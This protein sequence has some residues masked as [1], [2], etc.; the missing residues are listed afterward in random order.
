ME[1][2]TMHP[3][4]KMIYERKF[5]RKIGIPSYCSSNELVIEVALERAKKTDKPVLIEATANQVNQNGGYTGMYPKDFVD[6]VM[7]IADRVGTKKDLIILG[8]DHLGPLTWKNELEDI[9]ME[10]AK[11][12]VHQYIS[13]GFTKIHLDTSMKLADDA[14]DIVLSTETIARRGVQLYIT[15]M[16]AF[17]E[18]Q[19]R[20]SASVRPVFIIGSEVPIPG[21][22]L[23]LEESVCITSPVDFEDTVDTYKRVFNEFGFADAWTDVIAVVVQPGV[24]FGDEQVFMY[25]REAAK[26]LCDQ[27]KNYPNIVFEGHSTDYQSPACLGEMVEDGIA[28]LKVGPAL[29]FA[30]REALFALDIIEKELIPIYKQAKFS[31]TLEEVMLE[32]PKNWTNHL[33][34]ETKKLSFARKYSFSDRC[35]YYLGEK[36]VEKSINKLL[37][38]LS[39]IEIP[40]NILHQYMPTQYKKVRD[41]KLTLSPRELVKDGIAEVMKEYEFAV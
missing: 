33:H 12:L 18:L 2:S 37:D 26:S 27:L 30:L 40:M 38:N 7:K 13:A 1:T 4:K 8:G 11:I 3:L 9:A 14:T 24:E 41:G 28:I 15:A 35:R 22:A 32:K 19:K 5:G 21:G 36:E 17:K 34:G 23:D 31:E 29:T 10:K 39:E 6:F 16:E 20:N 25:N